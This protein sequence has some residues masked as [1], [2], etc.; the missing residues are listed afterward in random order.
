MESNNIL[1]I[2]KD[3]ENNMTYK[4]IFIN[5]KLEKVFIQINI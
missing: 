5:G 4:K 1:Q 3:F 2:L